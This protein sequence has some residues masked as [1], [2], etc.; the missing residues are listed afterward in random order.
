MADR[1]IKLVLSANVTGLV[2]GLKTAQQALQDTAKRS[3]DFVSRNEANISHLSN[4]L[5]GMGLVLTA[6]F[7]YAVKTFADFDA[8]MSSVAAATMTTGAELE[9]LRQAAI[10]AG[11][12]TSFSATEA[13][14]AIENL[15]KAGIS[16][17][18][19]L[20]GGL[21]G[22]LD[23][24]AAGELDVA[25]AAE[26][27][28][29]AMTQFNLGGEDMAHVADLL[30]AG[31][32]KAQGDV[33][34]MAEA[35]KQSGLVASQFGLSLEETTGTL[36]AFASAGLLGSDAGTSLR[37]MLLR[38]GNPSKEA[39][40]EM[41]RLGISAYD[42]QGNFVG[43]SDLAGQLQQALAPLPQ[44]QRDAALATI[45]GSD[46]IRSAN[47]LY[48]E[49]AAGVQ[50]WIGAV[51]DQGYAAE[52]AALRLDNLKGDLEALSG[53]FE[54]LILSSG[55][56]ANEWLRSLV[57]G[58]E[59]VVDAFAQIP[60]PVLNAT[61]L[62]VGG[63]G[64]VALGLA[65][66]GKLA[67]GINNVKGALAGMN[68]SMKTAAT[69][70]GLLGGALAIATT[71]IAVWAT[72]AAN[73]KAA[74]QE[75]A[76]TLDDVGNATDSTA[77]KLSERLSGREINWWDSFVNG[78]KSAVDLMDEIGIAAEDVRGYVEGEAGAVERVTAAMQEYSD[79]ASF[80][81][82]QYGGRSGA[83]QQLT[84]WL[85]EEAAAVEN[86]AKLNAD[87][88][89][90]D[91]ESASA[92]EDLAG[93]YQATTSEVT[94]QTVALAD[95][96]AAQ[97]EAAG[98]VL[99]TRDAQRN[100][101]QAVADATT[102]LAENGAT[103]DITTQKGRDNQAA[104]DG[105]ASST[106]DVIAAMQKNG[107][108]QQELQGVMQTSR[109]RFLGVATAAGMSADEANALADEL[110]LIPAQVQTNIYANTGQAMSAIENLKAAFAGIKDRTV[111]ITTAFVETGIRPPAGFY[112]PGNATGGWI[113]GPGTGTSD[114]IL[115]RLSNGEFVVRADAAKRHGALLEAIN[116]GKSLGNASVMTAPP[117][118]NAPA[119]QVNVEGGQFPDTVTLVD[120]SGALLGRMAVV[121]EGVT[122]GQARSRSG[123][124]GRGF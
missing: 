107:A 7:G 11:A 124:R 51:D 15:A 66:L 12:A 65:G 24:A 60:E 37:T 47:V 33:T 42:A 63:G 64:L 34:D 99:T 119:P 43:M 111:Q 73:A 40:D 95:L 110:G 57:Q 96:I 76:A 68:I 71:A 91:G 9:S 101:E 23:L 32:G 62:L 116:S 85:D 56:G 27:A 109:D 59:S 35:L 72:N 6:G 102:K 88:A 16:T 20:G 2:S 52:Q 75:Y 44:A 38:L 3:S 81:N 79:G 83:V 70:A 113:H 122:A 21:Q 1:S 22:A 87:K 30:A 90:L 25:S 100:F 17:A 117:N 114:S 31:A 92:Q 97:Q 78:G 58:A 108:S 104:L 14:G 18:D 41:T 123:M 19:I 82:K 103:L 69:T 10:D 28:A 89:A 53:S 118:V 13:A 46:A 105:I 55:S 93:A 4:V 86:G 50:E 39:A 106:W 77:D 112:V 29:T 5:G 67:I 98:V 74:A 49:G 121:A 115:R 48:K 120:A 8:A 94:N 36:A 45:F 54:S 84:K 61:T 26:I 80:W